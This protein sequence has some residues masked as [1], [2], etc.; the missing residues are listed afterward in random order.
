MV[1]SPTAAAAA[2]GPLFAGPAAG[3]VPWSAVLPILVAVPAIALLVVGLVRGRLPTAFA[4]A[5]V[6][7]PVAAY[8]LGSLY[9]LEGSKQT[10]FCGSCH[11]M[12]PLLASLEADD[13]SLA[14]THF[15]RGLVP[16]D[17]ACYT[18]HSGYGIWGGVD[19]KRAGVMHMIRTVTGRYELP[20][21]L[22]GTFDIDSCLGCHAFA[23]AFR[24][25]A[26]HRN[27]DLQKQIMAHEISCTGLCHPEAH[28]ASARNGAVPAS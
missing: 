4:A 14:S 16:H 9:V 26:D 8:A 17:E 6:F 2:V 15:T 7:L 22:N 3:G 28:P 18:C 11:V 5:A 21:K 19:A 13:G 1:P 27:P 10:S 12:T 20:L 25:V 24:A 23:P